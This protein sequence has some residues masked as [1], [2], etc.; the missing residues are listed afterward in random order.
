VEDLKVLYDGWWLSGVPAI[1]V[2]ARLAARNRREG[3]FGVVG[4]VSYRAG[5]RSSALLGL[6]HPGAAWLEWP[7]PVS[8]PRGK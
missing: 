3:V 6:A 5:R 7:F 8:P 1:R 2:P 4:R